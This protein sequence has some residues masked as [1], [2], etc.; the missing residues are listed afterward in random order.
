MAKEATHYELKI[1]NSDEL[2]PCGDC[3]ACCTAMF[4]RE[5][6]KD[7]YQSCEHQY[8]AG[9]A[10][11]QDRPA[12]C[13]TFSCGYKAGWVRNRPDKIGVIAD[14]N[15]M[16]DFIF[17]WEV[18]RGAGEYKKV[19]RPIHRLKK[20]HPTTSIRIVTKKNVPYMS[21]YKSEEYEQCER[22]AEMFY[23]QMLEN[24]SL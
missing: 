19:K 1:L 21:S 20:M 8:S 15:S 13:R 18:R 5:I 3:Q 12:S 11:Y 16:L 23:D 10:I 17:I 14:Y 6:E 7:N 9:C 2:R 22:A 4:D 24:L